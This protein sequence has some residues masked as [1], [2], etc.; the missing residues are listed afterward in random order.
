MDEARLASLTKQ[1]EP[2][3][4][5]APLTEAARPVDLS[6]ANEKLSGLLGGKKP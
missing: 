5:P 6:Q 2:A 4:E 3:V 1:A